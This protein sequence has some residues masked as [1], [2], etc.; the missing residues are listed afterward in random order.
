MAQA[1]I[2]GAKA[3]EATFIEGEGS[4][5]E[6]I[7]IT[8]NKDES[9]TVSIVNGTMNLLY[10]ESILQDATRAIVSYNDAGNSVGEGDDP[11]NYKTI[12]EGLPLV[13]QE[14]VNIK[15]QDN[16]KNSLEMVLYVNKVNPLTGDTRKQVVQLEL[17][18]REFIA[19]EKCR[20]NVRFDGNIHEHVRKLLEDKKFLGPS[21][22]SEGKEGFKA[23]ELDIEETENTYNFVGNNKKPYYLINWLSRGA[24]PKLPE[25]GGGTGISAG[26][27]FW[28]TNKGLHFKSIDSLF[29]QEPKLS[30]LYNETP[31]VNDTPP[32]G[33]DVK[34]LEYSVSNAVNVQQKL[35]L[36]AYSTRLIVFNP[37]NTY[38]EVVN[39]KA[40][41]NE[42]K[43]SLAGKELPVL[44]KEFNKTEKGADFSRT[45]YML[46]DPGSL[47]AGK[48][49]GKGQEQIKKKEEENFKPK[50]WLNQGIMRMNQLFSQKTTITIPADFT[51]HAGDAIFVDAPQVSGDPNSNKENTQTGGLYIIADL[52][53]YMSAKDTLTKLNLVRD[54]FGRKPKPRN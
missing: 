9:K 24:V 16:N 44:N 33:Y 54:S 26:F 32:D 46:L 14:R 4:G 10:Y 19:N 53:H 38:Y 21:E 23:K 51:L 25:G 52:C 28:E 41:D 35:K 12:T 20:V 15:I 42:D 6:V 13:G 29:A 45:T 3:S 37:F 5:I 36:G 50:E 17:A 22:E 49:I 18:S 30:V 11:K 2:T 8:S 1:Q 48:G 47:P 34:A 40:V 43:L 31:D 7:D 39:P 27:L